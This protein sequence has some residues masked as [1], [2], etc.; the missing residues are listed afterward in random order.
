M[1][2]LKDL[3]SLQSIISHGREFQILI[4]L[5]A[6]KTK[7]H[8]WFKTRRRLKLMLFAEVTAICKIQA[9]SIKM[10]NNS[11]FTYNIMVS[12]RV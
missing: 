1:H 9:L 4:A 10:V 2:C 3:T 6:Y 5:V 7:F 12:F 8:Q 11:T